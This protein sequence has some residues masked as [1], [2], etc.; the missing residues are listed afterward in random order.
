MGILNT[1]ADFDV[2]QDLFVLL[3]GTVKCLCTNENGT[4]IAAGFSNGFISVLDLRTG[5]LRG[6]WRAHEADILQVWS[7]VFF[8]D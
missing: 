5:I 8:R 6:Q 7:S 4:W 2:C 3:K 1:C